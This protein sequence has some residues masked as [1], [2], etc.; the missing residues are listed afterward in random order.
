MHQRARNNNKI[1]L[2]DVRGIKDT[3]ALQRKFFDTLATRDP[4]FRIEALKALHR[5]ISSREQEICDALMEDFSKPF[6]ETYETEIGIILDEI[7]YT[8]RHLRKW[9]RRIKVSSPLAHFPSRSYVYSEPYGV[10]LIIAPW[11]YPFQ[12]VMAPLIGAIAAGNC[13]VVKTAP[14]AP[15]TSTV[16]EEI[17]GAVFSRSHGAAFGGGVDI[18]KQLLNETYDYIFFTGGP[19]VGKI[20]AEK[21]ARDLTPVTL[22]LGGKSPCIVHSDADIATAARRIVWG[23]FL[24]CGQ[25]CVAPDYL[26]VQKDVQDTLLSH[27]KAEVNNFY[28]DN[29]ALS[30]DYSRIINDDHFRRLTGLLGKGTPVTGG[31]TDAAQRYIAPTILR[32]VSPEDPVMQEEIFGPILPVLVYDE[33]DEA[34]L[35][36]RN[37]DKPLAL[38][39]FTGSG[40]T[41]RTVIQHLSYGG[42]CINDTIVHLSNPE[43][44]FGGVG[45]SGIGAYHGKAG[46]DLFS[47]KKSVLKKSVLF[48][49]P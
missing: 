9:A 34:I 41:E 40:K 31:I 24:N 45:M 8:I 43:L 7:R 13:V 35:F 32:D 38:Y 33:L 39:L 4:H 48:D 12:L 19:V 5:E 49:L 42:G 26:L 3:I 2:Q 18:S 11:N 25:T 27:M 14:A 30:P 47:H 44:P 28:G 29:P 1:S 46:F 17:I 16:I 36:V 20:I 21:A 22:E 6:H 10:V 37:R 23:K 15:N